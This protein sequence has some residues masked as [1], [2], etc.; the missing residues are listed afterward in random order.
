MSH[1][2]HR[3]FLPNEQ[4]AGGGGCALRGAKLALQPITDVLH[5]VHG[6][7]SCLGHVWSSRPT[8][9]SGA[10]LHR[11]TL[12]SDL[13][14]IDLVMG[15]D[16]KLLA[17]LGSLVQAY[18]PAA[19]FVYQSC[20]T[21]MQGVDLKRLCAEA[22][23]R[24]ACPVH[25]ID[26][27]GFAAGKQ[28]GHRHAG[29][30]LAQE[31]IG[32]R[33]SEQLTATDV[34]VIGE[35]NVSG[36]IGLLRQIFT[37]LGLRLLASIPG[38]GRYAELASAHR[39]KAVVDLCSQA[40]PDLAD[41]LHKQ[42]GL[43]LIRGSLYGSA[44][45]ANLLLSLVDTLMAQ[46]ADPA[47]QLRCQAYLQAAAARLEA[48]MA[49]LRPRLAGK[50][51]LLYLGGVKT[52]SLLDDLQRAGLRIAGVSLHKCTHGDKQRHQAYQQQHGVIW[53]D[54][55]L[56][57]VL[58]RKEADI[59]LSGG[60]MKYT[61]MQHGIPCLELSHERHHPLLG[62][63]GV[64][65]LLEEID[66]LLST[67]IW[68]WPQLQPLSL[69][70]ANLPDPTRQ[71]ADLAASPVI[72]DQRQSGAIAPIAF[73]QPI[74][75]L[76]AMQ[77]IAGCR[78]LL[79]GAAGC[80]AA[81]GIFVTRQFRES[82]VC[83]TIGLD[84]T[85]LV[86]GAEHKVRQ[87]L[88]SHPDPQ[89]RYTG[90]IQ[91]GLSAMQGVEFAATR[92]GS[93]TSSLFSVEVPDFEGS[94]QDGWGATIAAF[95]AHL[96]TV[97]AAPQEGLPPLLILAGSHLCMADLRWLKACCKLFGIEPIVLPD[98]SCALDGH[99]LTNPQRVLSGGTSP[100]QLARLAHCTHFLALGA[101]MTKA[102][103]LLE[104]RNKEGVLLPSVT[105]VSATDALVRFLANYAEMAVPA[106]LLAERNRLLQ[107]MRVHARALASLRCG[108]VAEPD[109]LT[110]LAYWLH[111]CGISIPCAITTGHNRQ[112]DKLPLEQITLGDYHDLE[113]QLAKT[114]TL[115][116]L[117]APA[118]LP[119]HP[120]L[121]RLPVVE[122]GLHESLHFTRPE[123]LRLGYAGAQQ[124]LFTLLEK[125]GASPLH[126]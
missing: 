92:L 7:R 39:A 37:A 88:A 84:E 21:A 14:E 98:L 51:V 62:A 1:C 69:D 78:P 25:A 72:M 45:F 32:T 11:I 114:S 90:L 125:T 86:L 48:T 73:P 49:R 30:M 87:H 93:P 123:R 56:S 59:V 47:L 8:Q 13:N 60:G 26:L 118:S 41:T 22:S 102:A 46:G 66:K 100:Q 105:G 104:S 113:Q 34:T 95:L 119:L 116:L 27:P 53:P 12:C 33:E 117:L 83:E 80:T 122:L 103:S 38:D 31:I 10:L 65:A 54:Q 58:A 29:A 99:D 2:P 112:L 71:Q 61:A 18:H 85:S 3:K 120:G 76:L 110:D 24:L 109:L 16:Q 96:P 6:T 89:I 35:F 63:D 15:A 64:I 50:R 94:L 19:I 121:S 106:E 44:P 107:T 67:P 4:Q 111:E 115:D 40:L 20:L 55:D 28:A 5:L 91:T 52:W 23:Q 68:S 97:Q 81:A 57:R 70:N 77:G 17:L 79:T 75:A 36:E 126:P 43:P 82:L 101:Q 9:S 74:G 124:L 108:L 42:Y